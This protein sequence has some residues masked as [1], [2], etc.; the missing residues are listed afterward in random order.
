MESRIAYL[1]P[2][3]IRERLAAMHGQPLKYLDRAIVEGPG[4]AASPDRGRAMFQRVVE[5]IT[6]EI[7]DWMA[8]A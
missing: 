1:R 6:A 8:H 2:A 4:F 3:Q 7:S 5:E